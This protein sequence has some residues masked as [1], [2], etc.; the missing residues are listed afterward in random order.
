MEFAIGKLLFQGIQT[1][2]NAVCGVDKIL[3]LPRDAPSR[4]LLIQT[5]CEI[6]ADQDRQKGCEKPLCLQRLTCTDAVDDPVKKGKGLFG[7]FKENEGRPWKIAKE[8]GAD[9]GFF[10]GGHG[11][12]ILEGDRRFFT[13]SGTDHIKMNV[14]LTERL[15]SAIKAVGDAGTDQN[16]LPLFAGIGDVV[17]GKD[18]SAVLNIDQ[19]VIKDDST[20]DDRSLFQHRAQGNADIGVDRMNVNDAHAPFTSLCKKC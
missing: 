15:L 20:L 7:V 13:V 16:K 6:V 11:G 2:A 14:G 12:E 1:N 4:L 3:E 5:A 17:V 18:H 8:V 10:C 9:Q 19:L